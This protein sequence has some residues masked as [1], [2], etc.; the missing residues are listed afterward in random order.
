MNKIAVITSS[1]GPRAGVRLSNP[2][3]VYEN[4]DYHAFVDVF[5][6]ANVWNQQKPFQ[7]ST[8]LNFR[9]RRNAKIYKILP[10]LFFPEYDYYLRNSFYLY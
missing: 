1:V 7:F 2:I 9:D 3:N 6:N 8:D 10:Q 5:T 4:V